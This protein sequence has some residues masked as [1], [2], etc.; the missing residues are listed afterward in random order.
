MYKVVV[1]GG[2]P[3]GLMCAIEAKRHFALVT[4]IEQRSEYTRMN[5]P[6][7]LGESDLRKHLDKVDSEKRIPFRDAAIGRAA[8]HEIEPVLLGKAQSN[9]VILYRPFRITGVRGS[10]E[11]D[12]DTGRYKEIELDLQAWN[13]RDKVGY[14]ST[15]T[16]K[17][18]LLI[19]ATGAGAIRDTI[20][21]NTLGFQY[22]VLASKNYMVLGI[23]EPQNQEDE[24]EFEEDDIYKI[25]LS[26]SG[27]GGIAFDIGNYQYFLRDLSAISPKDF[28]LIDR[29]QA[30]LRKLVVALKRGTEST[31]GEMEKIKEVEHSLHAFAVDIQR[32]RELFSK[33]YPAILVGDAAVTPH[34]D[35]G[36][37]LQSGFRGFKE[38]KRLLK[39]MK[40]TEGNQFAFKSF[41]ERYEIAVADKALE[42][43][44][45][46]CNNNIAMLESFK[47]EMGKLV[48]QTDGNYIKQAFVRDMQMA[49]ALIEL[50]KS[51]QRV[52]KILQ[53]AVNDTTGGIR[54][55][56]MW[57]YGPRQLWKRMRRTWNLIEQLANQRPILEPQLRALEEAIQKKTAKV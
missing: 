6:I 26:M 3:I 37:G 45:I 7:I 1:C 24:Y 40:K 56:A 17:A 27:E 13:S 52:A 30:L 19:I 25:V 33:E 31:N 57:K 32:A 39:A 2:G 16:I 28:K 46:I 22:E 38:V 41:G 11:K 10:S 48:T 18:N 21:T 12:P 20:V 15:Y 8:F 51:H 44:Q 35:Q 5:V 42:G 14:G 23:F 53:E 47:N 9:G 43:T 36:S 29:G 34:P 50:L 4:L 54:T 49:N 55:P